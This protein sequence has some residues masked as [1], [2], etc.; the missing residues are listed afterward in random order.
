MAERGLT[1]EMAKDR[2]EWKMS[3]KIPTLVKLGNR[4]R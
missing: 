2:N 4:G 3:I 1:K